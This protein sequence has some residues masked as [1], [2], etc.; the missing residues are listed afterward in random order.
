M[1]M[2]NLWWSMNSLLWWKTYSVLCCLWR[3]ISQVIAHLSISVS[4]NLWT[5]TEL[6][7]QALQ[8]FLFFIFN[9]F[10]CSFAFLVYNIINII[11]YQ[12]SYKLIQ[13]YNLKYLFS[14]NSVLFHWILR[15]DNWTFNFEMS[16]RIQ[17]LQTDSE[18]VLRTFYYFFTLFYLN[19]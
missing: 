9:S 2:M 15:I 14:Q 11:I 16:R 8:A 12:N 3:M 19:I 18:N 17:R 1:L 13:E 7:F 4:L 6:I 10:W 5:C